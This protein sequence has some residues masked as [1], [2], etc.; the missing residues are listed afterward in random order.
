[1]LI[2]VQSTWYHLP[3]ASF[4]S[5]IESVAF[6]AVNERAARLLRNIAA[7]EGL[8]GD[9]LIQRHG[10]A[11]SNELQSSNDHVLQRLAAMESKFEMMAAE[12]LALA[13]S[14][15]QLKLLGPILQ[16]LQ[17]LS[18]NQLTM[19]STLPLGLT[20]HDSRHL[21]EKFPSLAPLPR[22]IGDLRVWT[23]TFNM[24]AKDPFTNIDINRNIDKLSQHLADFVPKQCDLY[25][26]AVQEGT[27]DAFLDAVSLYTGCYRLPLNAK[28]LPA[29]L[30]SKVRSRRMG[31]AMQV[32]EIIQS[33]IV[34]NEL[35]PVDSPGDM[36]CCRQPGHRSLGFGHL[37]RRLS[38]VSPR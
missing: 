28:L 16:Q 29:K 27:S 14:M 2:N 22:R 13:D 21:E 30:M 6:M 1:M 33:E 36:V 25:V 19:G 5:L 3:R 24:N 20:S 34:G 18:G 23:G 8:N 35:P 9:A 10:P 7:T 31:H 4:L 11:L 17:A 15:Q 26:L 38:P 12:R 37:R 32:E